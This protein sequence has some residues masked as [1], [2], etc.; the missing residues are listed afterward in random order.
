MELHFIT[1][2][3]NKVKEARKKL[4]PLGYEVIQKD[5]DPPEIQAD[6]LEE[7]AMFSAEWVRERS[8]TPFFLEDSG[9]FVDVLNG[10]PGVYSA[11]VFKTIGYMGIL[12]LMEGI[13]DRDARFMAVI[14]YYDGNEIHLFR[15]EV[16]GRVSYEPRGDGGFGYD[17]IFI[18]DGESRTFAEMS[19]EE[20][21]MFSHRGRALESFIR[22]LE[23]GV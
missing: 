19:P 20:K 12:R 22:Y 23:E 18:P 4:S 16:L 5:M 14:A 10:F 21:N 6:S 3:D 2:N 8:P 9:F 7:V 15:G 17:P 1:G 11:Y 13:E